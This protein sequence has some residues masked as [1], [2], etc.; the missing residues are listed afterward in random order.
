MLREI[1]IHKINKVVQNKVEKQE[2]RYFKI[3]S[4]NLNNK[5]KNDNKIKTDKEVK[6]ASNEEDNNNNIKSKE[7]DKNNNN[8]KPN[9]EIKKPIKEED[10]KPPKE[11]E[12]KKPSKEEDKNHN[13]IKQNEEIKNPSKEEDKNNNNI[14]SNEEI[15]KPS[16]EEDKNNNNLKQNEEIKNPP[17]IEDKNN[18]IKSNEEIKKPPK[19]ED[20]INNKQHLGQIS[21]K[22]QAPS[23]IKGG[24]PPLQ[25]KNDIIINKNK[26]NKFPITKKKYHE[27]K[28]MPKD[29]QSDEEPEK[30]LF[31]EELRKAALKNLAINDFRG[32]VIKKGDDPEKEFNFSKNRIINDNNDNLKGNNTSPLKEK[33]QK[34]QPPKQVL[35]FNAKKEKLLNNNISTGN[36][37]EIIVKNQNQKDIKSNQKTKE[38][39]ISRY[40]YRNDE[41]NREERKAMAHNKEKILNKKNINEI[42]LPSNNTENN[43]IYSHRNLRN[44]REIIKT[45]LNNLIKK[46]DSYNIKNFLFKK[47]KNSLNK[48]NSLNSELKINENKNEKNNQN[49]SK[50][51]DNKDKKV[52]NQNKI[53]DNLNKENEGKNNNN[54][55]N[56]NKKE[57]SEKSINYDKNNIQ[58]I[59]KN[60]TENNFKIL[61]KNIEYLKK[62]NYNNSLDCEI[63]LSLLIKNCKIMA[64]YRIFCLYSL[65]N[66]NLNYYIKRTS[67]NK[68]KKNIANFAIKNENN[69][70]INNSSDK[71]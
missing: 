56:N 47:W 33:K 25:K 31:E 64:I 32:T 50:T 9:E 65:F 4:P 35:E 3:V 71:K 62:E 15:K 6:K 24:L 12:N 2:K 19:V 39:K 37:N 58:D 10:K 43:C 40:Y 1:N 13:N 60:A 69:N 20:K 18:N 52:L 14:K 66:Q 38:R 51:E 23:Q 57:K 63:Y 61:N 55:I 26:Y 17:K 28:R 11:E 5:E 48:N 49:N 70:K 42:N 36:I 27:D 68:W 21:T 53:L 67:F 30:D 44:R 29:E 41:T 8:I 54:K 34:I 45:K 16:K 59:I 46:I 22:A 7:E